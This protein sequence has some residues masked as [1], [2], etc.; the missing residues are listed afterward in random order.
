MKHYLF[1]CSHS[2][3]IPI[4]RP[5][6]D[7]I[8]RRNG[9]VAWFLEPTCD[10]SLLSNIDFVLTDLHEVKKWRPEAIFAP[11]N[12]IYDFFPGIKVDIFHGYPIN[13]R[14]EAVPGHFRLRGWF[15][16]YCTQGP[17]S[18]TEFKR[19]ESAHRYFKVYETGW[20]KTDAIIKA[21]EEQERKTRQNAAEGKTTPP[22]IFV[23]STFTK[24]ITQLKTLFPT[25]KYLAESKDWRWVITA[26]PKLNDPVLK[27]E[28]SL[29]SERLDNVEYYP[30]TPSPEVMAATDVMLCDTSSIMLEYMLLDKPVVTFRS[31]NQGPQIMNIDKLEDVEKALSEAL[32]RPEHLMSAIREYMSYHDPHTDGKNCER[33]LDAVEDFKNNWQGKMGRKPLNII[34][35]LKIRK[36]CWRLFL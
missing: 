32:T 19:L 33:I 9:R 10:S 6:E 26:H 1:F 12:L 29:L 30:V 24:G 36:R 14:N 21:K 2:Y 17:S 5:L 8:V 35:K 16:I 3:A 11:G 25:I 15:D 23:A 34:R 22:A 18:T 27:S 4:L 7:A 13:K 28:L 31:N 20:A